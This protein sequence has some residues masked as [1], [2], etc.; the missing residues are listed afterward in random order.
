MLIVLESHSALGARKFPAAE[1]IG[2]C[3]LPNA[4]K[5]RK[6]D[7]FKGKLFIFILVEY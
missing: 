2:L 7:H 6:I 5:S 4:T 3:Q 1:K